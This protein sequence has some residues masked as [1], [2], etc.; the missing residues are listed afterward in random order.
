MEACARNVAVNMELPLCEVVHVE[1]RSTIRYS[2]AINK[3]AKEIH[4]E[5]QRVYGSGV[6]ERSKHVE[7]EM[8]IHSKS[9]SAVW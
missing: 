5:I 6:Y 4:T 9:K 2:T 7:V 1:V 3:T 8:G